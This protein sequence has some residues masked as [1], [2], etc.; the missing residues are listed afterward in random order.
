MEF[1]GPAAREDR[2]VLLDAC[3]LAAAVAIVWMHTWGYSDIPRIGEASAM[4]LMT[5]GLRANPRRAFAPYALRRFYRIYLPFLAWSIIGLIVMDLHRNLSHRPIVNLEPF[6]LYFGST[7]QLWF[8]PFLLGINLTLFVPV[9]QATRHP[10][11]AAAI[12]ILAGALCAVRSRIGI[13]PGAP[14]T[15]WFAF[16][17]FLQYSLFAMPAIFWGI[18]AAFLFDQVKRPVWGWVGLA[19]WFICL[20]VVIRGPRN[21]LME[22]LAGIGLV[23]ACLNLGSAFAGIGKY[24]FLAYG[25]YLS[26]AVFLETIQGALHRWSGPAGTL[27]IFFA[28]LALSVACSM[29]LQRSTRTRWM[30]G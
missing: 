2:N 3:R 17:S 8:L 6:D 10:K 27:L 9:R 26:H 11:I 23:V 24:A 16:V 25:I 22:N 28:T 20:C 13:D 30:L 14:D 19:V 21:S 12:A 15:N 1:T 7:M 5:A 4:F 29:A 18:A